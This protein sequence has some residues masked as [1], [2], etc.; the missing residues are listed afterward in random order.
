MLQEKEAKYY[1]IILNKEYLNDVVF[2]I[3][4]SQVIHDLMLVI[5][6][7]KNLIGMYWHHLIYLTLL[8]FSQNNKFILRLISSNL[9]EFTFKAIH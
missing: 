3:I 7:I 4:I 6:L 8:L 5:G 9:I 2:P 1:E